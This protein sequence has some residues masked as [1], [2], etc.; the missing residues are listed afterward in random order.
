VQDVVNH[1]ND[2]HPDVANLP[3]QFYARHKGLINTLGASQPRWR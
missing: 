1:A 2:V 3:G